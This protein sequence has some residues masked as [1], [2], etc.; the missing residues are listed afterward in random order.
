MVENIHPEKPKVNGK[1]S[2]KRELLQIGA[3]QSRE[4]PVFSAK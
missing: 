3:V 2:R 4:S 1:K